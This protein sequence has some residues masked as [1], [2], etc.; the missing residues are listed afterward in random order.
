MEE[1]RTKNVLSF[2]ISIMISLILT[3]CLINIDNRFVNN[4]NSNVIYVGFILLF[5]ILSIITQWIFGKIQINFN[6]KNVKIVL[7][8][9]KI[10]VIVITIVTLF[11]CYHNSLNLYDAPEETKL[12][13]RSFGMMT[14]V[15]MVV[16][17]LL[18][19]ILVYKDKN[20]V[21]DKKVAV[22]EYLFAAVLGIWLVYTMYTPNI[23]EEVYE[24][25]HANA[26]FTSVYNTMCGA[27]RSALNSSVYGFYGFLIA[28][29][30]KLLG[31]SFSTFVK[32]MGGLTF[33]AYLC[34]VY[35]VNNMTKRTCVR[36]I[37]SMS[38][39]IIPTAYTWSTYYQLIP[40]RILFGSI[41]MAYVVF[42]SKHR[43]KNWLSILIGY[44]I[45]G[46]AMI[47]NFE[48]GIVCLVAWGAYGM[49]D[50]A[51]KYGLKEKKLYLKVL[52]EVFYM[53]ITL[54]CSYGFVN[55]V[56]LIL[57]GNFLS[58]KVFI[59]PIMNETSYFSG[60]LTLPLQKGAVLWYFIAAAALLFVG[61]MIS[62]TKF[63]PLSK[64][65]DTEKCI[66]A[67]QLF[68]LSIV[69]L[70]EMEY[71]INRS[72]WGNLKIVTFFAVVAAAIIADKC[73]T[74]AQS[75]RRDVLYK[76]MASIIIAL[77]LNMSVGGL[78]IMSDTNEMAK[79]KK[80]IT[81]FSDY[82]SVIKSTLESWGENN[83]KAIGLY[84]PMIYADIGWDSGYHTIDMADLGVYTQSYD[85][86]ADE[87][88]NSLNEPVLIQEGFIEELE[89]KGYDMSKFF[90]RFEN[91]N[92]FAMYGTWLSYYEP[93]N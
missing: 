77:M 10:L 82:E 59:F 51:I 35:V 34:C 6:N 60:S 17:F 87:L 30:L 33:I 74:I 7:G 42:I 25:Y 39:V 2:G 22:F 14:Y 27:P 68:L 73:I 58:F 71:Y 81:P 38:M 67:K 12:T 36:I 47:W 85:Y 45:C 57:G 76:G 18:S 54:A 62:K 65:I 79:R 15:S 5:I 84:I 72:A 16:I 37:A 88:N 86:Y 53:F 8:V 31:G 91:I 19:V 61:N 80:D 78:Y 40:H 28:P 93:R 69:I 29:V 66:Y 63:S 64:G 56:N 23:F 11:L 90:T 4:W 75:H 20:Y 44:L 70:G 83:V 32:I 9:L 13:Y 46:L 92:D 48:T 24:Y 55:I 43:M 1:R 89:S 3:V 49:S 50:A 41:L 21:S 26:Y 52:M